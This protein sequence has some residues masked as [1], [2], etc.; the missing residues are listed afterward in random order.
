MTRS[1]FGTYA[2]QVS[3]VQVKEARA[4]RIP[5]WIIRLLTLNS[6]DKKTPRK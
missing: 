5:A 6:T 4:T 3:T 1:M 2:P